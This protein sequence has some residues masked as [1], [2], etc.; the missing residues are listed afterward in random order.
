MGEWYYSTLCSTRGGL[1]N[2]HDVVQ[3]WI[4]VQPVIEQGQL[5]ICQHCMFP[6]YVSVCVEGA[7][8]VPSSK[9]LS[10]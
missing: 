9:T 10:F 4:V 1:T 3:L 6:L 2:V 5:G 8:L 7:D